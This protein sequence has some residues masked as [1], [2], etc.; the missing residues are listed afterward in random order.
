MTLTDDQYIGLTKL[1]KWYSRY[2]HQV[3]DISGVIG[4]GALQLVQAFI[5]HEQLDLKEIMWLSYDQKQVLEL[6]YKKYHAYYINRIIYNYTRYI[7]FDS[8]P[9]I[10]NKSNQIDYQWKKNV[11]NKIDPKYKLMIV[12]DSELLSERTMKDLMTFGLPIILIRDPMLLPAPDSYVFLRDP[13]ILLK[14]LHSDLVR[15]PIVYFANKVIHNEKLNY[16]TYD[17]VSIISK[18][19]LNLY[20]LKSSNMIITMSSNLRESVN[21]IYREK[22]LKLKSSINVAGEKIIIME[23]MYGHKLVNPDEKKIK[24]YLIKGT[25]GNIVRCNKHVAS[26]KY[27][28]FEFRPD[29]YY[30]IFEDLVMDRHHLNHIE[31]ESKQ[32]IPDESVKVEYAYALTPDLAR[33][34]HWDKVTIIV[35]NNDYEDPILQQ[36]L[37]YTALTRARQSLNI[38]L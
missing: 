2:N 13:N 15:N 22:V 31:M 17:S 35:D 4:T 11:R 21:H 26:T 18:R 30:D 34:S 7:D 20:N 19:Q 27:V 32:L 33:L 14:D 37:L 12:F 29:F 9:V 28:P 16:G 10:N 8:L 6:A 24:I 23:D 5:S 3:I 36:K 1:H 25:V 38:I